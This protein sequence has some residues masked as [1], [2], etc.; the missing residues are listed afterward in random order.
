MANHFSNK[1]SILS[2]LWMNYRDDEG[3]QDFVQYNDLGLPLAYILLNE[4][5]APTQA[6]EIYIN[7]TY[8]LFLGALGLPDEEYV[9]LDQMLDL[10]AGQQ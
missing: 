7:E 5:A 3:F 10:A 4:I 8:D 2:E 1:V 6:S 9:A